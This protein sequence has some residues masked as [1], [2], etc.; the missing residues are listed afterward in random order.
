MSNEKIFHYSRKGAL[1]PH[2]Q[3]PSSGIT[4]YMLY[5][6][7]PRSERF[8]GLEASTYAQIFP[9]E[10]EPLPSFRKAIFTGRLFSEDGA[11]ANAS[12][13]AGYHGK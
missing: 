2:S 9:T 1:L 11:H 13:A 10:V 6:A 4:A 12:K 3:M 8:L 7:I 5:L